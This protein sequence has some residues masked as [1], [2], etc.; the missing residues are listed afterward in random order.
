MNT[1]Y[2]AKIGYNMLE[3]LIIKYGW[4]IVGLLVSSIPVFLPGWVNRGEGIESTRTKNYIL[5]KK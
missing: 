2:K 1:I 3:D 5:T 4:T